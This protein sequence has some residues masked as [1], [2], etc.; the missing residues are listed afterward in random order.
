MI[1]LLTGKE[2]LRALI[3]VSTYFLLRAHELRLLD[4]ADLVADQ[5]SVGVAR[6]DATKIGQRFDVEEACVGV[7]ES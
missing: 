3:A 4:R 1:C 6:S 2:I 5:T 7:P